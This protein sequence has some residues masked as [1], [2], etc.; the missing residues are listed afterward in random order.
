[1]HQRLCWLAVL[2]AAEWIPISAAVHTERGGASAARFL[3][4]FTAFFLILGYSRVRAILPRLSTELQSTGIGWVWLLAHAG[5]LIVF[6]ALSFPALPRKLPSQWS[7]VPWFACGIGAIALEVFAFIKPAAAWQLIRHTGRSWLYA[8]AAAAASWRLI[9]I[10]WSLWNTS[11]GRALTGA[12]FEFVY[13]LLRSVL[14]QVTADRAKLAI[15]T[16]R[17]TVEIGDACSGFEGLGMILVFGLLWLWFFRREIR[18]P[19]ALLAVPA[20][21]LLMWVLNAVRIVLLICIG[22]FGASRIALGGFHSQ[23]GWI[24]FGGVTLAYA[25]ALQHFRWFAKADSRPAVTENRAAV[26]L[27][28]F[29]AILAA[30][31]LTHAA[32]AGFEWLYP[33]RFIA[34]YCALWFPRRRYRAMDWSLSWTVPAAG[35]AVAVLWIALERFYASLPERLHAGCAGGRLR[36]DAHGLDLGPRRGGGHYGSHRRRTRVPGIPAAPPD[37][38]RFRN[39]SIGARHLACPAWILHRLWRASRR[40]L[41]RWNAGRAP[42]RV[43]GRAPGQAR[44]RRD[45]ACGNQCAPRCL[46]ALLQSV[47]VVVTQRLAAC[48]CRDNVN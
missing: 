32:S 42:L 41:D 23:A 16:S 30:S 17:F 12:T 24:A 15:G 47:A 19:Q 35:V 33:L 8:L 1:L 25:A 26:Y 34:A 22:H 44:R 20:G 37:G 9:P 29:M 11:Q 5:A 38:G 43:R 21:L 2:L 7:A 46:R 31:L 3:I 36:R 40:S 28:P 4:A 13:I 18:F 27:A 39:D 45:R 48:H 14:P 10:S 6:L